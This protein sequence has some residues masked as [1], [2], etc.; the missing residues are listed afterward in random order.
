V[1]L[2][3]CVCLPPFHAGSFC[4]T[5]ATA[6]LETKTRAPTRY[7]Y[8]FKKNPK[9]FPWRIAFKKYDPIVRRHV[10]FKERKGGLATLCG[11]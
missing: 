6:E 10:L 8:T 1:R 3:A 11:A 4:T 7:F 2:P 9:A 5:I